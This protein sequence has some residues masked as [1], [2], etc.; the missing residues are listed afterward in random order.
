[1]PDKLR[2][3]KSY[4]RTNKIAVF[5]CRQ[6]ETTKKSAAGYLSHLEVCQTK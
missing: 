4:L 6:C 3:M 1:M 5:V 2:C